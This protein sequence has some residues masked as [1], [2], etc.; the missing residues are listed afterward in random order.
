[1]TTFARIVF[2]CIVLS[3]L[4]VNSAQE[5][6]AFKSYKNA[7]QRPPHYAIKEKKRHPIHEYL[8][9]EQIRMMRH[10]ESTQNHPDATYKESWRGFDSP[11]YR[12]RKL[13]AKNDGYESTDST[14]GGG[15]AGDYYLRWLCLAF[16][17][18]GIVWLCYFLY[19]RCV[20]LNNSSSLG[21]KS[22]AELLHDIELAGRTPND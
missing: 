22:S 6:N 12:N 16:V 14:L 19:H 3:L 15:M 18:G 20:H 1:M 5:F 9:K 4:Y 21:T 8:S 13:E 10:R 11:K 17:L 2:L 7:K